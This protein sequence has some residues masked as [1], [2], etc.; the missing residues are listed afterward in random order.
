MMLCLLLLPIFLVNVLADSD[1]FALAR[2]VD[3]RII[4]SEA[5]GA[6]CTAIVGWYD[7]CVVPSSGG[8][9]C[10]GSSLNSLTDPVFIEFNK[11]YSN[12]YFNGRSVSFF[13]E[14]PDQKKVLEFHMIFKSDSLT[15]NPWKGVNCTDD[16]VC[17]CSEQLLSLK[18]SFLNSGKCDDTDDYSCLSEEFWGVDEQCFVPASLEFGSGEGNDIWCS[19]VA[20][21]KMYGPC[22]TVLDIPL[23]AYEAHCTAI[24]GWY[25]SCDQVDND[26]EHYCKLD[27]YNALSEPLFI[28][29]ESCYSNPYLDQHSVTFFGKSDD[30]QVKEYH[31]IFGSGGAEK[32]G[33]LVCEDSGKC[34]FTEALSAL[35]EEFELNGSCDDDPS[36]LYSCLS[37][38]FNGVTDRC[39]VPATKEDGS[40]FFCSMVARVKQ[41]GPCDRSQAGFGVTATIPDTP[42]PT[43]TKEQAIET[44][45]SDADQASNLVINGWWT[46][47]TMPTS[48]E[49]D[50]CR[51]G[52]LVAPVGGGIIIDFESCYANPNFDPHAVSFFTVDSETNEMIGFHLLFVSDDAFTNLAP[53]NCDGGVCDCSKPT[54]LSALRLEL[55]DKNSCS[56]ISS[57][58][59]KCIKQEVTAHSQTCYAPILEDF[60]VDSVV[61]THCAMVANLE[62]L[63]ADDDDDSLTMPGEA[64]EPQ[65]PLGFS[66]SSSSKGNPTTAIVVAILSVLAV[67]GILWCGVIKVRNQRTQRAKKFGFRDEEE[68]EV[69][70]IPSNVHN[71]MFSTRPTGGSVGSN[72][73]GRDGVF[74]TKQFSNS[75]G[76]RPPERPIVGKIKTNSPA[77]SW[78]STVSRYPES[79][80]LGSVNDSVSTR[81][82]GSKGSTSPESSRSV[83]QRSSPRH[84][85]HISDLR[86]TIT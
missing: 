79:P 84:A 31:I 13:G 45:T 35:K 3:E 10:D 37:E 72:A 15:G 69:V 39:F 18:Q 63:P 82:Y 5:H 12:P 77:P 43:T 9:F 22:E 78:S 68:D 47:C 7:G 70:W 8:S 51:N 58:G 32:Y 14:A 66:G 50:P 36:G 60:S 19:M 41:F 11:C 62:F 23:S 59:V 42:S 74:N 27:E 67:L 4:P 1:A 57:D 86:F 65:E 75:R 61:R 83:G 85:K 54:N 46:D 26:S 29:L 53:T 2:R 55:L 56:V 48:A 76:G 33:P 73:S 81:S 34:N 80:V 44:A 64:E 52:N 25:S 38:D 49:P 20:K 21:V 28:D 71:P 6:F 40:E 30:G 17:E 24:T 16:G